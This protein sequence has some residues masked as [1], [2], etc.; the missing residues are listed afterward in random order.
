MFNA[1]CFVNVTT[2]EGNSLV[3]KYGIDELILKAK[4]AKCLLVNSDQNS[5]IYLM[6]IF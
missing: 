3:C 2:Q 1:M 5:V 6:E 4:H